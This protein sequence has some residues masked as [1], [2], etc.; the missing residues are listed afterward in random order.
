M[1]NVL[2]AAQG[3]GG[4]VICGGCGRVLEREFMQLDHI[5]PKSD[6]GDERHPQPHPAV[7]PLQPAQAR[8]PDPAR[9][10]AGEQEE[11]GRL[12]GITKSRAKL[13]QDGARARA[14]WVR[15][16]FDTPECQAL[17][18]GRSSPH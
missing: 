10:V 3:S 1:T 17:I 12:D 16:N 7:R 18:D 2:A 15:D 5:T 9:S 8:Q 13:A 11:G 4:G 14:D 6:R